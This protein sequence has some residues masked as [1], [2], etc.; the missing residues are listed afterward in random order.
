MREHRFTPTA[1]F[2]WAGL[3]IWMTDFLFVYVFAALACARGFAEVRAFGLPVVPLATTLSNVLACIATAAVMWVALRRMRRE[4]HVDE[5]TQFIR[6]LS[7]ALGSL[8]LLGIVWL[9]LPPLLVRAG[10]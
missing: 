10:C 7:L 4:P 5:H 1:I 2:I 6:F 9:A 3:L 8:A